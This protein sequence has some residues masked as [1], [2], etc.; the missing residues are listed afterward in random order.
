MNDLLEF[1]DTQK[2]VRVISGGQTGADVTG[3][4]I[5]KELG[6]PTGGYAPKHY[7]TEKGSNYKLRDEYGLLEHHSYDY[8]PRTLE[9]VKNSDLTVIFSI[10]NSVGSALTKRLCVK[11]KKPYLMINID[12]KNDVENFKNDFISKVKSINKNEIIL[13]V[14]GSRESKA[15]GIAE[16]VRNL[17]FQVLKKED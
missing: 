7:R 16:I 5:A 13:N 4:E 12:N 15:E 9:N 17:L 10:S 11:N 14:A 8:P 1:A 3:L 2:I 6:I